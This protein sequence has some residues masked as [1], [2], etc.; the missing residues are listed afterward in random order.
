MQLKNPVEKGDISKTKGYKD[1][2]ENSRIQELKVLPM[3]KV[4]IRGAMDPLFVTWVLIAQQMSLSPSTEPS[5]IR[6]ICGSDS[7]F[8]DRSAI[9]YGK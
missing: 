7:R 1:F 3:P 9:A 2:S 5:V 4:E 6:K 8:L